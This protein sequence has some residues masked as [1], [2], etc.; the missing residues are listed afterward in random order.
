MIGESRRRLLRPDELSGA[1]AKIFGQ[2]VYMD[3]ESAD[4]IVVNRVD[5]IVVSAESR[6]QRVDIFRTPHFGLTLALDGVC[7]VAEC[8]EHFY[9][10]LLIHPA[11]LMIESLTSALVLG[12]GDGC[13]ARELLKYKELEIIDLVEIDPVVADL[14]RTH[15]KEVNQ[16]AL[17]NPRARIIIAE[18]ETYLRENP[19]KRYDLIVADLTE[20]FAISASKGDLSRHI[21]SKPFYNFLKDHLTPKG[22]LVIQTGG[23]T[24]MP[25]TDDH[26]RRVVQGLRDTFKTA[27]T[28]YKYIHSFDSVWS[29]TLASDHPYPMRDFEPEPAARKKGVAP[30]RYYDR[31]SHK[32]AFQSRHHLRKLFAK[33]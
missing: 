11:C 22:I 33:R 14:C 13:A 20:P 6:Y 7:Q 30:L 16:S 19:E 32:G 23:I 9:H 10:E 28:A 26:H 27:E 15:F 8:D 3:V 4:R 18:G 21:F 29:V 25:Q 2:W 24:Y 5:S 1:L 12:G 17:D 31:A